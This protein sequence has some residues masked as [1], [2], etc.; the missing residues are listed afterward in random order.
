[1]VHRVEGGGSIQSKLE[2]NSPTSTVTPAL[3]SNSRL[4]LPAKQRTPLLITA[5][6]GVF[7]LW[8]GKPLSRSFSLI[9]QK[10]QILGSIFIKTAKNIVWECS[11][12]VGCLPSRHQALDLRPWQTKINNKGLSQWGFLFVFKRESS[13]GLYEES[14]IHYSQFRMGRIRQS[15]LFT[16]EEG[17]A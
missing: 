10:N 16:N 2:Q 12:V 9:L 11:S 5:Q 1:M 14:Q 3:E 13:K 8:F 6:G 4:H 7:L 17:P 15:N